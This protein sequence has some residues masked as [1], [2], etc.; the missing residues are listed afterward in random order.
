M[1]LKK[2]QEQFFLAKGYETKSIL[3]E[4]L[5]RIKKKPPQS[6]K[7]SS[8]D[9]FET[10]KIKFDYFK[11]YPEIV[12][13]KFSNKKLKNYKLKDLTE[14]IKFSLDHQGSH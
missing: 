3:E 2:K 1:K 5:P 10:P 4:V 7:L 9:M 11:K 6:T 14:R 12:G 8:L 13:K